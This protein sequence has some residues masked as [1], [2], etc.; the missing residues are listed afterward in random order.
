M[1][2]ALLDY[3]A[4]AASS[5]VIFSLSFVQVERLLL[6]LFWLSLRALAIFSS[7]DICSDKFKVEL[8]INF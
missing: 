1:Y 8:F 4:C 6:V 3:I 2:I 7:N 5:S